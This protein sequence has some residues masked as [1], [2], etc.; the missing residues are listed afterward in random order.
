MEFC[1]LVKGQKH[2]TELQYQ[3]KILYM[4]WL[5]WRFSRIHKLT[6]N[7]LQYPNW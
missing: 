4:L 5:S 6:M 2:E 3:Q 7:M 1:M